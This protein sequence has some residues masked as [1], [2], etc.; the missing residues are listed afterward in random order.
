MCVRDLYKKIKEILSQPNTE[1]I[2]DITD[3]QLLDLH[4]S[5]DEKFEVLLTNNPYTD[6]IFNDATALRTGRKRTKQVIINFK[7]AQNIYER[8][9]S[10]KERLQSLYTN[11]DGER[12]NEDEDFTMKLLGKR[13]GPEAKRAAPHL[14]L[15][16]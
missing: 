13:Q 16:E 11:E 4:D 14:S 3:T 15:S 10:G 7:E 9:I 1:R 6:H 2:F 8:K 5:I 12:F